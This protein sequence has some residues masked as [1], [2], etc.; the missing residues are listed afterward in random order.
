MPVLKLLPKTFH[1][2]SKIIPY[3]KLAGSLRSQAQAPL[4]THATSDSEYKI[5]HYAGGTGPSPDNYIR[6]YFKD[7]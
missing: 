4:N 2:L 7:Q 5:R 3:K 1:Q 6:P